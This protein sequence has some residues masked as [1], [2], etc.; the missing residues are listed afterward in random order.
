MTNSSE[1]SVRH[2]EDP[3]LGPIER[4]LRK[5]NFLLG[6]DRTLG[7]IIEEDAAA[8]S[9]HGITRESV[10][11]VLER[12]LRLGRLGFGDSVVVD[13]VF[14]V[15]VTEFRG[16]L[17]CPWSDRFFAQKVVVDAVNLTNGARLRFTP[18]SVHLATVHGFFQGKGSPFRIDPALLGKFLEGASLCA[19]GL[20]PPGAGGCA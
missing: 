18:L 20:G 9:R 6:E 19:D 14:E 17:P 10:G 13:G 5:G 3:I 2:K 16:A 12:L 7:Q 15:R 11:R 8:C 1:P 4:E